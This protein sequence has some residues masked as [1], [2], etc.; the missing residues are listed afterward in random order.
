MTEKINLTSMVK[1]GGCAS[2]LNPSDLHDI[3]QIM[4]E[5]ENSILSNSHNNF[6]D[7]SIFTLK[8]DS[9]MAFSIDI[10]APIVN[11][12]F[13]FGRIAAVHSFSDIYAVG[14]TPLIALN[15]LC[16]DDRI[17][18]EV[19][20]RILDGAAQ[21]CKDAG[22]VIGG[23]HTVR[24]P[25]I[26]FGMAVIGESECEG[27]MSIEGGNVGDILVLTKPLGIGIL[28]QALKFEL[29]S[30]DLIQLITEQMC[31]LNKGAKNA[32]LKAS[33]NSATD[34]SGFGL[35]Y[36][37]HKLSFASKCSCVIDVNALPVLPKTTEFYYRG[38]YSESLNNNRD[39]IIKYLVGSIP[40]EEYEPLLYD[41]QTSGGLLISIPEK[42]LDCLLTELKAEGSTGYVIGKL[43]K[44][45]PGNWSV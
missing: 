42:H 19:Y 29:L 24:A 44:G 10:I 31:K 33:A 37:C 1:C 36:D 7:A 32:M 38:I 41:P 16:T 23:G 34:V 35:A 5:W 25:E 22:V 30:A 28:S 18:M 20:Q 14:S 6:S 12:P 39:Y 45:A 11:D 8:K 40:N 15:V 26:R 4:P 21:A 13:D 27:T 2:K 9:Q 3:L 43:S 17:D